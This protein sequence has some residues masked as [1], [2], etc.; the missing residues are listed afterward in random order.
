MNLDQ[1]RTF[2]TVSTCGSFTKA[3]RKLF[4]T[5]PAVSQ[6]IQALEASIGVKLFDR[7][8]NKIHLTRQGEMLLART[9]KIEYE[10]QKI[11]RLF[12]ELSN[13]GRGKLE[14]GS[15]AVFGTYF[16]PRPIGKFNSE[17]PCIE[18]NLH[19]GNSHAIIS[20]LLDNTIEIGFGGLMED[21]PGIGFSLIHQE[22]LVAVVGMQHPL[23]IEKKISVDMLKNTPFIVREKGTGV[24]HDVEKWLQT[25]PETSYP[26]RFIELENVE[27]AKR[28]VEEGFGVTIVPQ[29]AVQREHDSGLLKVISFPKFQLKASYYLY[30]PIKRKLSRATKTFLA[31][32]PQAVFLSHGENLDEASVY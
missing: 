26:E 6:Q 19:A 3:S 15:S 25:L 7:S 1:L 18:I 30:Y 32:L 22:P 31:M 29:V 23:A 4:L 17:Y 28:V 24:H 2:Q 8:R 5:Q 10:I 12:S 16:L 11:E 21:E 14:I 9:S 20:M 13:L 27:T